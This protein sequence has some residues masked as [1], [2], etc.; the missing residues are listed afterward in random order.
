M[1]RRGRAKMSGAEEASDTSGELHLAETI[2][3]DHDLGAV[4]FSELSRPQ[5]TRSG[6]NEVVARERQEIVKILDQ[7]HEKAASRISLRRIIDF[8]YNDACPGN[9]TCNKSKH[10][11]LQESR[12]GVLERAWVFQKDDSKNRFVMH[13]HTDFAPSL[14]PR[15]EVLCDTRGR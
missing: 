3:L 15:T 12:D 1:A 8:F 2:G 11:N 14:D 6:V 10:L 13:G 9:C 5:M 4:I 7:G